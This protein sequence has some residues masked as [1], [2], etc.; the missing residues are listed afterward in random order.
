MR[1]ILF[2]AVLV[3]VCC[4]AFCENPIE[5]PDIDDS[6]I[7]TIP[8]PNNGGETDN[9]GNETSNGRE[10][11][12]VHTAGEWIVTLALTCEEKGLKELRCI[13]DGAVMES[14]PLPVI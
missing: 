7:V 12:H 11:P 8:D 3:L 1:K 5:I 14:E 10:N 13:E 4:L 9:S 6:P 2:L